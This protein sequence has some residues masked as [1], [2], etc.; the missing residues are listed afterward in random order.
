M[1]VAVNVRHYAILELHARNDNDK[2]VYHNDCLEAESSSLVPRRRT[3]Q[4]PAA[5]LIMS[6]RLRLFGY[7]APADP[8]EG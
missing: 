8:T 5:S 7:I 6:G 4:D 1:E 2:M 3:N